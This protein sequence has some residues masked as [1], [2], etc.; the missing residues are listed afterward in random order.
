MLSLWNAEWDKNTHH[1]YFHSSWTK[2]LE[3]LVR[4]Q[5]KEKKLSKEWNQNIFALFSVQNTKEFG[6]NIL[7]V[8]NEIN[9]LTG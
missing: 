2:T 5:K 6:D 7:S 8:I 1:Y 9:K 3:I 4:K